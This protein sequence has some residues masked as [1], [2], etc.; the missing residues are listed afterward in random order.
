[1][2]RTRP[3]GAESTPIRAY[4]QQ[5]TRTLL[6]RLAY[7]VN[8]T[9]RLSDKDAVHDL[10]VAIRR[11]T[12]CLR[13]FAQFFPKGEA[14]KIRHHL[15]AIMQAASAVR[16][17]D[18]TL[19]LMKDAGISKKSKGAAA[20]DKQRKQAEKELMGAIRRLSHDNFSRKW[21]TKLEL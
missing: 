11:F 12:Q 6:R 18:I 7:Q 14:K 20:I 8:Q 19:D 17:H 21:R 16:D 10:R 1:M 9:I 5:Q 4:A 15:R 3:V 13:I 2:K